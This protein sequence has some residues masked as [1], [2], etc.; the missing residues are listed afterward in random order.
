MSYFSEGDL[1]LSGIEA[2]ESLSSGILQVFHDDQWGTVCSRNFTLGAARVICR[3]LGF[4]SF[5]VDFGQVTPSR[6]Y[7]NMLV[8][9]VDVQCNGNES[10]FDYCSYRYLTD[11]Y[12]DDDDCRY[13]ENVFINCAASQNQVPS[14]N[15]QTIRLTGSKTAVAGFVEVFNGNQWESVCSRPF[16]QVTAAVACKEL[17]FDPT[18]SII[19]PGVDFQYLTSGKGSTFKN[20][21]RGFDCLGNETALQDCPR[22]NCIVRNDVAVSCLGIGQV[23]MAERLQIY[24]ANDNDVEVGHLLSQGSS[25]EKVNFKACCS[26]VLGHE[27]F[28]NSPALI[29]A[30]CY[31]SVKSLKVLVQNGANVNAGNQLGETPVMSAAA[32]G[33]SNIVDYLIDSGADLNATN[34]MGQS[35]FIYA[36]RNGN[37]EMVKYLQG[38]GIEVRDGEFEMA[39]IDA[40][41]RNSIE[42]VKTL[43]EMGADVNDQA[44]QHA[45]L[46]GN[47]E[48]VRYLVVDHGGNVSL[49]VNGNPILSMA[50]E[51]SYTEIVQCLID[52]GAD[53]EEKNSNGETPLMVAVDHGYLEMVDLLVRRGANI[54]AHGGWEGNT[55]FMYAVARGDLEFVEK[56]HQ[57]APVLIEYYNQHKTPLMIAAETGNLELVRYIVEKLFEPVEKRRRNYQ[58]ALKYAVKGGHFEVVE[59]LV[60]HGASVDAENRLRYRPLIYAAISGNLNIVEYLIEK[61]ATVNIETYDGETPLMFAA[62]MGNID[63]ARF[64]IGQ[65]ASIDEEDDDGKDAMQHAIR[66]GN[67]EMVDLLL[68]HTSRI[69]FRMFFSNSEMSEAIDYEQIEIIDYFINVMFYLESRNE[70]LTYLDDAKKYCLETNHFKLVDKFVAAGAPAVDNSTL[71]KYAAKFNHSELV[72]SIVDTGLNLNNGGLQLVNFTMI[73]GNVTIF[74]YIVEHGINLSLAEEYGLSTK[75][76]FIFFNF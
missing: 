37:V 6:P 21:V 14:S 7:G 2:N 75:F 70:V 34:H 66:H 31:G 47:S 63:V 65:G 61:G 56:I 68:K 32:G 10:Q 54:N 29:C 60:E 73:G 52:N 64:F 15:S 67:M 17:G 48:M 36:A 12:N 53:V 9:L 11:R 13:L 38:K 19:L 30:A 55:V 50:V 51:R 5:D 24:I 72:E 45:V 57:Y 43:I 3:Q 33:F 20:Q 62:M 59:Y 23:T 4:T 27:V 18:N 16:S 35:S 8:H 40:I 26:E 71:L 28:Q 22:A 41:E 76:P 74:K 39:L 44:L 42:M 49:V 69:N 1:R 58:T 25:L 46:I